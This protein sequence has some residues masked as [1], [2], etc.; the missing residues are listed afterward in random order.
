[1]THASFLPTVP[2]LPP[3]VHGPKVFGTFTLEVLTP[4]G[5]ATAPLLLDWEVRAWPVA[6]LGDATLEARPRRPEL[7]VADLAAA[8]HCAGYT[9]LGPVR[10]RPSS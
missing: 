9:P 1:M 7:T 4:Q 5:E 6:R 8:L 10:P 3:T 2:L